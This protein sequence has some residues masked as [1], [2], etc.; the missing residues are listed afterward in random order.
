MSASFRRGAPGGNARS[1]FGLL[2]RLRSERGQGIVEFALVLPIVAAL[3]YVFVMFGKGIYVYFQLTHAANAGARLAAVN[4]PPPGGSS[5]AGIALRDKLRS[6]Y[7]L[8]TGANVAICYPDTAAAKPRDVGEPV[9]VDVYANVTFIPFL[10]MQIKGAATMRI[11]QDT[12]NN[13]NLAPTTGLFTSNLNLCKT[14][15]P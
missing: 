1:P 14:T 8:P 4:L 3:L 5:P 12:T 6:D 9:Q 10:S 15:S 7:S 2:S 11:E 13:N